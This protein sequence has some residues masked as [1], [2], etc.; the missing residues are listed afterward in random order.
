M[1][2]SPDF[3]TFVQQ[4]FGT[5]ADAIRLHAAA[6]PDNP[7]L[8]DDE[9]SLSY[10]QLDA[11]M[12][13]VAAALQRDGLK[14]GDAVAVCA[15]SSVNYAVLFLGALRAGVAVAPLAPSSTPASL[16]RMVQDATGRLLF[17]DAGT[18]EVLGEVSGGVRRIAL[19]GSAHGESFDAWLAAPGARPAPAPVERGTPFNIIYSS[20]T[21]GE[22]K[23]I[24]QAH[25]MRWAHV[26]R[27]V[28]YGYGPQSVTLLST[29]LYSNTTLVVFFPSLAYGGSVSLMAKFDAARYLQLAQQQR[30]SHTMLV[31]VQYQRLMARPDFDR[32][33]LSSFHFKFS[34]SAPFNAALKADVLK[35]WPGGLVEFYGM[36]EGG[37]TCILEAHLHPDK[38]HTVGR[39]AEGSDIRLIDEAGNEVAPGEAGEVVGHSAGMMTGYHGQPEKT[40][41]AEWFDAGGKR[42]I[43]TGDIGRFDA[44]GFLTLFDRRKDMIISGGFN[45]Y[46]SDLEA[47][48]R[49]HPAVQEASVVGVPSQEW[50]E[51]PVGFV[52]A[53]EGVELVEAEA[54]RAWAN[55][56]LGKTQRL[57]RILWV[58]ELP[59]SAIGKVLKRELRD[60]LATLDPQAGSA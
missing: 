30:V 54:L 25:G 39:P 26:R 15:A 19:D 44:E 40:R 34:T 29:P 41:E 21:T 53:R 11:L 24:V 56:Q 49:Q 7:A 6:R 46:P 27:G 14:T 20:G 33:D 59:R 31:P 60:R 18:V 28:T 22:P 55:A 37:G 47:V 35:R 17:L 4:D 45:I 9:A 10:G 43:R 8:R 57:S 51:T 13:R 12:D 2:Q 1:S 32:H 5:I 48:L 42:F 50:G 3:D 58:N 23:G 52:V 16:A 36:T 38:L